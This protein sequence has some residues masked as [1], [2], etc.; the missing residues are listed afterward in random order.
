MMKQVQSVLYFSN[1]LYQKLLQAYPDNHR[2][3]FSDEMTQVFRDLCRDIYNKNGLSGLLNLWLI[4]FIDIAKTALEERFKEVTNMTK[5]KFIRLGSWGLM[6]TGITM[7]VAF[8]FGSFYQTP[9]GST[10]AFEAIQG[11]LWAAVP[12]LFGTGLFALRSHYKERLSGLGASSLFLGGIVAT[13][14]FA[15]LLVTA[16]VALENVAWFFFIFGIFSM[17]VALL[18]FGF[19]V[20]RR[21]T[22]PRWNNLPLV[23]GLLFPIVGI[24]DLLFN[25]TGANNNAFDIL[26]PIATLGVS[27]GVFLLGYLLQEE[28]KAPAT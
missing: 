26:F 17:A 25:S 27:V 10:R 4:T 14:S 21:K 2:Q 8:G 15:G 28:V 12:L 18:F 13:I 7:F 24:F 3:R 6:L 22:M 19:D 16:I 5:E 23:T 11:V 20:A 9:F 1:R